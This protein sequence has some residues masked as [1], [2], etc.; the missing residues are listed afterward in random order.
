MDHHLTMGMDHDGHGGM[1]K[2][3]DMAMCNMNMLFTWSSENLCI[4]FRSW[5]VTG[6]FSLVVSL[7]AIVVLSAGYEALR[8]A[9]RRRDAGISIVNDGLRAASRKYPPL[10][11]LGDTEPGSSTRGINRTQLTSAARTSCSRR[12]SPRE[13]NQGAVLRCTSLLL[14][15]HHVSLPPVILDRH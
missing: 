15:L 2:H 13:D 5:R 8:N 4:V 7:L 10:K 12:R 1:P 9:A 11:A 14:L 6:S 3:G